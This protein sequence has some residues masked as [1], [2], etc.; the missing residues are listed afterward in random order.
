MFDFFGLALLPATYPL[1]NLC[2]VK[3][4]Q[5]VERRRERTKGMGQT[6]GTN[7]REGGDRERSVK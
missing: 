2:S 3:I 4:L 7:R 5:E 1:Q 6:G